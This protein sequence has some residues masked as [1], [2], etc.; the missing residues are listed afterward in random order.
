MAD[1][2]TINI[3]DNPVNVTIGLSTTPDNF[4]VSTFPGAAI[5]GNIIGTL[6][7]QTDL[8][9][10]LSAKAL[11]VDLNSL[12]GQFVFL[13][14][15]IQT[16]SASWEESAEIIPT[17]TNYL[18][19]NFV[20]LC[21]IDSKG[22]I[23]SAGIPLHNIFLTAETDSQTLS[24]IPSSYNLSISNGNTVNLSSIV[25][26]PDANAIFQTVSALALSGVFYGD[27]SNLIGASL[28]GQA[29]IN[30]IV[31]SNSGNWTGNL[32]VLNSTE[33]ELDAKNYSAFVKTVTGSNNFTFTNFTSGKTITLYLSANHP[34]Y[35]RHYLPSTTF[36]NK[37]GDGNTIYT[38]NNH[39]TK[40]IIQNT[41]NEY[42]GTANAIQYNV[43]QVVAPFGDS[44]LLDGKFGYL[45]QE[46][47][48]YILLKP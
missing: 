42:V 5:W 12:S 36:L 25:I 21:S 45:K 32:K 11:Q 4:L 22:Q 24:Y 19:T 37:A 2:I 40:A 29:Q 8:W 31:Q 48:S 1:D 15:L 7:N 47:G 38:F 33:F 3:V 14:T 26:S 28:P 10:Q 44:I 30:S 13:N 35:A 17:I 34:N 27:G 46:N 6:S 16:Y 20:T 23:L 41:G 39:I 43:V 9:S 18:S